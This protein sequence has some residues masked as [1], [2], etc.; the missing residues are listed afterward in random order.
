M[1]QLCEDPQCNVILL[2]TKG[3]NSHVTSSSSNA[4]ALVKSVFISL[5]A[6][7][8]LGSHSRGS[9]PDLAVVSCNGLAISEKP[10]IQIW[11]NLAAPRNSQTFLGACPRY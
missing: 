9:L 8:R 1:D 7:S 4:G 3:L 5:K 10:R 6:F 11:Q 2:R